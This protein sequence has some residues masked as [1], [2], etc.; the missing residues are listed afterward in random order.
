MMWSIRVAISNNTDGRSE[1]ELLPAKVFC[2]Q[3][4]Y[5]VNLGR[6]TAVCPI[7]FKHELTHYPNL[8]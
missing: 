8:V 5:D 6:I 7:E 3:G 1:I 2:V 4:T